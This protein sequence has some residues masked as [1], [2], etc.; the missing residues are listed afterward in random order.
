MM[1]ATA[2]QSSS[3]RHSGGLW[4]L[5]TLIF[6]QMLP[7]TLVTP[8]IRPLFAL[9]HSGNE[10]AMHTF[11]GINMLGAA[12]AAP[13]IGRYI[14]RFARPGRVIALLA[15]TD[16]VLLS[17]VACPL[18]T[19]VVLT[20]RF[21]EGAAHVGAATVL[22]AEAAALGKARGN[23]KTMG[24]AGAAIIFAI[25]L[26]SGLGGLILPLSAA[27]PFWLGSLILAGLALAQ[28][29]S[30]RE[31]FRTMTGT[32]AAP[33]S[34]LFVR[35]NRELWATLGAAFMERF[36]V[37]C[38][39]VTFS[40]FAHKEH[41]LSDRRI[42]LLFSVLTLTF[43]V[44]MY[45]A[46]RL[47]D[48]VPRAYAFAVGGILYAVALAALGYVPPE[49][50]A[51]VMAVA[52]LASSFIYAPTL[53]YA[54]Q[55][56]GEAGKSRAMALVNAA[57]CLGM[58]MGP[59]LAGI[60]TS[61]MKRTYDPVTAYRAVFLLAASSVLL[62]LVLSVRWLLRRLREERPQLECPMR[63]LVPQPEPLEEQIGL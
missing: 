35:Q 2:D 19:G 58:L 51:A 18:A 25:A 32:T 53:S 21:L 62:W 22:L 30:K 11:M 24:L 48:R 3:L 10:G 57:G 38:I 41:L 29:G 44:S 34:F 27:A 1:Q 36:T 45:P 9:H 52:G 39:V 54:A 7:A 40:L 59:M 28:A 50:L 46:G 12:L 15:L 20:L 17:L 37:G 6:F 8:A 61:V 55:L 47:T 31:T 23:G 5:A 63:N 16:A 43:A 14:H 42:G 33:K 56:A 13:L 60:T 4:S 49:L 26:G